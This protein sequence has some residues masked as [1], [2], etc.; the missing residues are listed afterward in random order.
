M[1]CSLPAPL[2]KG[3]V[4]QVG[5]QLGLLSQARRSM[6][7]VSAAKDNSNS[8]ETFN[9]TCQTNAEKTKMIRI[10]FK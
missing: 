6:T 9:L 2:F 8:A 3:A 10:L 4:R 7:V 1:Q 5:E